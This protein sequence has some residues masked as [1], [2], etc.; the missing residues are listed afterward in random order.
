MRLPCVRRFHPH[1]KG[2]STLQQTSASGVIIVED[3][4]L[5]LSP[6]G[7]GPLQRL[8]QSPVRPPRLTLHKGSL[9]T[10]A[11]LTSHTNMRVCWLEDSSTAECWA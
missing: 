3:D 2:S 4:P 8:L 5:W 7:C 1:L 9:S 11:R 6:P 10:W